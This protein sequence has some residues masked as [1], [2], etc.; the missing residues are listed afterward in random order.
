VLLDSL[1]IQI[2]YFSPTRGI[3]YDISKETSTH[4]GFRFPQNA[5]D[6]YLTYPHLVIYWQPCLNATQSD[7]L[8]ENNNGGEWSSAVAAFYSTGKIADIKVRE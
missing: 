8:W 6:M 4:F 2:K 5:D 3:V 7:I 1:K